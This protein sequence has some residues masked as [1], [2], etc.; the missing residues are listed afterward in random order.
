M[1]TMVRILFIAIVSLG[2][3]GACSQTTDTG[4]TYRHGGGGPPFSSRI[5]P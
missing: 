1:T 5:L 2:A 4:S 3:L